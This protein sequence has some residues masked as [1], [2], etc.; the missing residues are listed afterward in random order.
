MLTREAVNAPRCGQCE[1]KATALHTVFANAC[2]L[3]L[4]NR[5][6]HWNACGSQQHTLK[7]IFKAHYSDLEETINHLAERM[8]SLGI[9][10][11]CSCSDI[12][13]FS[14]INEPR[15][16]ETTNMLTEACTANIALIESAQIA[17]EEAQAKVDTETLDLLFELI[18][19][20][21]R[22]LQTLKSLKA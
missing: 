16:T 11:K 10:I 15:N 19:T 3:Y 8:R 22:F 12:L 4:I 6:F 13:E 9:T 17:Q 20:H 2:S 14:T 5:N 7:R 18:S 21:Q 1:Q